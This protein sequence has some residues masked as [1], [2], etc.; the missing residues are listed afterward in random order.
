M[1][2]IIGSVILV[3]WYNHKPSWGTGRETFLFVYKGFAAIKCLPLWAL[4]VTGG[5][6]AKFQSNCPFEC[7]LKTCS[8]TS[9]FCYLACTNPIFAIPHRNQRTKILAVSR[10]VVC[11]VFSLLFLKITVQLKCRA[12]IRKWDAELLVLQDRDWEARPEI[13]FI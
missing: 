4:V 6:L 11:S 2:F 9:G 10:K 1:H 12:K 7:T 13:H 8:T 3:V 5:R